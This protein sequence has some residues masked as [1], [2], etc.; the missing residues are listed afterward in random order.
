MALPEQL[1][2]PDTIALRDILAKLFAK[3]EFDDFLLG[4]FN[5]NRERE[6]GGASLSVVIRNSIE[7]F[8]NRSEIPALLENARIVRPKAS[9]L[10]AFIEQHN[11]NPMLPQNTPAGSNL[12]RTIR[13]TNSMLDVRVWVE[14]LATLQNQVCRVEVPV[15]G[16]YEFGTGFLVGPDVIIT[17]YHVVEPLI[18][19]AD[20]PV[21]ATVSFDYALLEDGKTIHSGTPYDLADNW[22]LASS[23]Y[24]ELD[25]EEEPASDP[26]PEELD[27]ALLRLAEPAGSDKIGG[28]RNR[29]ETFQERGWVKVPTSPYQFKPHTPLYIL[30]HP[31]GKELKLALESDAIIKTNG[32]ETRVRYATNTEPGSSGSPCFDANWN[33]V[34]LHHSGDPNYHELHH[35][36]YNQGIPFQKICELLHKLVQKH[37]G[38]NQNFTFDKLVDLL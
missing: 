18:E 6:I 5:V 8:N 3:E 13:E 24:S 28:S 14:R 34:A 29:M 7:Y 37:P 30:Q 15:D 4:Q 31:T 21:G 38:Y 33:L 36:A 16:E 20:G 17:N 11:G 19:S 26:G 10:L 32:K 2:G 23:P 12:E 25:G 27:F 35:P 22:L 1:D 9:A